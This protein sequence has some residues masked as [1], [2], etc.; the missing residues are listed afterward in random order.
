MRGCLLEGIDSGRGWEVMVNTQHTMA[1]QYGRGAKRA[2]GSL[3]CVTRG[4]R[5]RRRKAVLS[6]LAA[7]ICLSVRNNPGV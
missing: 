4:K 7:I 3:G 1:F 2:N 5:S 6:L